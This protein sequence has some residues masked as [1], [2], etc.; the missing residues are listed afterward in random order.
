MTSRILNLIEQN[1]LGTLSIRNL[2]LNGAIFTIPLTLSATMGNNFELP[3]WL[4]TG[5]IL[6][7]LFANQVF[8]KNQPILPTCP[9]WLNFGILIAIFL[10]LAN[11]FTKNPLVW[12][13]YLYYVVILGGYVFFFY[14]DIHELG[15]SAFKSYA[16]SLLLSSTIVI[17][18][19]IAQ[20]CGY[21]VLKNLFASSI[22]EDVAATFGNINYSGQ[23]L[24]FS[25]LFF[26][27]GLATSRSKFRAACFFCG[28]VAAATYFSYINTRSIIL[29]MTFAIGWLVWRNSI[30]TKQRL[31]QIILACLVVIPTS[32]YIISSIPRPFSD[33]SR[34]TSASIR[35]KMWMATLQM[36]SDNPLGV[37]ID[38]FNFAFVPYRSS[39]ILPVEDNIA[40]LN[41][42]NEFLAITAESGL[43][44]AL[45]IFS[46]GFMLILHF[47]KGRPTAGSDTKYFDFVVSL[48]I[49]Y[50]VEMFFQFPLDGQFLILIFAFIIAFVLFV[51][52]KRQQV[53]SSITKRLALGL[54]VFTFYSTMIWYLVMASALESFDLKKA[55]FACHER[56]QEWFPCNRYAQA[57]HK[58]GDTP[59]AERELQIVLKK[60]PNNWFA[61]GLL[62]EIFLQTGRR[63]E[64][65]ALYTR[66]DNIFNGKSR[67]HN[68]WEKNCRKQ[69]DKL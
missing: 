60:Q 5:M 42:H 59:A 65:C 28:I 7:L 64:G 47:F 38:N 54:S 34:M 53:S 2:L 43:P 6:S 21:P 11:I 22:Q 20:L 68:Y 29:G 50:L 52:F 41:P 36:I 23:F 19:G 12:N 26:I 14:Q 45:L 9:K 61:M 55:E 1:N 3:K 58:S 44:A 49:A 57:L 32:R 48:L 39:V 15:D 56:P 10:Q 30:L 33:E 18:I 24:G 25:M 40:I 13:D 37:G 67:I 62:G 35:L 17:P 8:A 46:L 63:E 51:G 69:G 66:V 4:L 27:L 31:G 16:N